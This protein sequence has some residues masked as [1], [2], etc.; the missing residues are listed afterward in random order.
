MVKNEIT[1]DN[2]ECE[3][4]N[5]LQSRDIPHKSDIVQPKAIYIYIYI[6]KPKEKK[7][8]YYSNTKASD[9][10]T[11][12]NNSNSLIRS[13][14]LYSKDIKRKKDDNNIQRS[15]E[16]IKI[17][18]KKDRNFSASEVNENSNMYLYKASNNH[19]V[20]R[21]DTNDDNSDIS[22]GPTITYR[23]ITNKSE[24]RINKEICSGK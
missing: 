5:P 9:P 6:A 15:T 11:G 4:R 1:T 20:T 18:K 3:H 22:K 7:H 23:K 2:S 8:L 19:L 10:T 21:T 12:Y 14:K 17:I 13:N 16:E 24:K